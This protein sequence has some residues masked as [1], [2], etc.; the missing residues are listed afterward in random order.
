MN[1]PK[2]VA[3]SGSASSRTLMDRGPQESQ[4]CIR[5]TSEHFNGFEVHKVCAKGARNRFALLLVFLRKM[6]TEIVRFANDE[7]LRSRR[8][9]EGIPPRENEIFAKGKISIEDLPPAPKIRNPERRPHGEHSRFRKR[10]SKIGQISTG[11][12]GRF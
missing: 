7:S 8:Q 11:R 5:R 1:L 12:I 10:S 6:K 2:V 9:E 3:I 4:G